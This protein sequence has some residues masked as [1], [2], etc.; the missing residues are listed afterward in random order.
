MSG[1]LG[2]P[3]P[4]DY[5]PALSNPG[6]LRHELVQ[7]YFSLGYTYKEI[8]VSL[9]CS[10]GIVLS[11]RHLKRLLRSMGLTRRFER[12]GESPVADI[13]TAI[14]HELNGSGKCLGYRAMWRRLLQEH[15]L[16]IKRDT[17]LELMWLIDPQGVQRRKAKRLLRRNYCSAGP[18]YLWHID[19]YDK[20]K[21]Y[22]FAIHGAIDGFSRRILW[23]RVG[24]T[25]NNPLVIAG[26][27]LQC[28]EQHKCAPRILRCDLGT[29]NTMLK[30]LQPYFRYGGDDRF[31]GLN[32]I[33]LGKS[34][35]NQRIEAWWSIY[36]KQNADWWIS[37]FKDLRDSGVYQDGNPL[38]NECLRFCFMGVI[39]AELDRIVKEW[40]IHT[41]A[42]KQNSD[43]PK[44]KPDIM[45][46]NP[47]IYDTESYGTPIDVEDIEAC[48]QQYGIRLS[49]PPCMPEFVQIVDELL[50]GA[51]VPTSVEEACNT[52]LRLTNLL[53]EI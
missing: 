3:L 28:L 33:I 15:Q 49:P 41:I 45:Y 13:I 9:L 27:Y 4:A 43:G 25:N 51:T 30:L 34:T 1:S 44:G 35:S 23:L 26:Y 42:S 29:E 19:G 50:P 24:V 37:Y 14:I 20:L 21:P 40:N 10:H 22:G 17:V 38:H 47:D 12:T 16:H 46:F 6:G 31:A 39:Q 53:D 18:N 36:R 2:I 32:S 5:Q 7:Q 11:L 48:R 52:F 8:I